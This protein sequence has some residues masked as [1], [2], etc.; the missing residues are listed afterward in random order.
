MTRVLGRSREFKG[1]LKVLACNAEGVA[2][3][4]LQKRDAL[5]LYRELKKGEG[6]P[7]YRLRMEGGR[8]VDGDKQ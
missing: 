1:H 5:P 7:F 3:W 2:D 8:I 4:T 6:L